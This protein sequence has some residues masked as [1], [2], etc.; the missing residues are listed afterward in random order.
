MMLSFIVSSLMSQRMNE[1]VTDPAIRNTFDLTWKV[2]EEKEI[3][4]K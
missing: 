2:D 1:I 4:R 3:K